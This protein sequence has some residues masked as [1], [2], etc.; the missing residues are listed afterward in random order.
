MVARHFPTPAPARAVPVFV[1]LLVSSIGPTTGSLAAQAPDADAA[2][3][4]RSAPDAHEGSAAERSKRPVLT[5]GVDIV[6]LVRRWYRA[7]DLDGRLG[8]GSVLLLLRV[9]A[10]GAVS[11][12]RVARSGTHHPILNE[13]ARRAGALMQFAPAGPDPAT[14]GSTGVYW[15]HQRIDFVR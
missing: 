15:V 4:S 12:V 7:L 5:N 8:E 11:D 2:R 6:P 13:L 1:A 14:G 10:D 9:E 3:V